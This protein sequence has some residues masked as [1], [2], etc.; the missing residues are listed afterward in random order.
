M[1]WGYVTDHTADPS[2]RRGAAQRKR[3]RVAPSRG[4][5]SVRLVVTI[6]KPHPP[7]SEGHSCITARAQ[8]TLSRCIQAPEPDPCRVSRQDL[9]L[10]T[11]APVV[12]MV[13][14]MYAPKRLLGQRVGLKGHE[15]LIDA[16]TIVREQDPRVRVVFVGGAWGG[17]H[18]YEQRVR[19]YARRRLGPDALFLGDRGDVAALYRHFQVAVHPSHSENLGGAAESLLLGVPTVATSVGGFP[20][21][22]EDGATGLLVPPHSPTSLAQG[23]LHSAERR[24]RGPQ[25][26]QGGTAAHPRTA[27]PGRATPA[28]SSRPTSRRWPDGI[29]RPA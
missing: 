10:D 21:L 25:D 15:D 12:G 28:R 17:A 23:H 9:G 19:D 26:G 22:V 13:A 2:N 3:P 7:S 27:G 20:D 29:T 6:D 1:T 8:H 18:R 5:P 24:A 11:D 14:Y 16:M 4:C